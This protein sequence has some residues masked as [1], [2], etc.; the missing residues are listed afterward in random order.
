MML[1]R[2]ADSLYWIG[3]YAERAEHVA[4]LAEVVLA[5]SVEQS[6]GEQTARIAQLSLAANE[7]SAGPEL[8]DTL[9]FGE[10]LG[11]SVV[12]SL[13][14]ARENA[15]Q[16]RD[17]VTTEMWEKLNV[18]HLDLHDG[19]AQG[20]FERGG[21]AWL[22]NL[23]GELHQFRGAADATMSHGE[24]WRFLMLG[25]FVERAQLMTSLLD[26]GFGA[27]AHD[28]PVTEHSAQISLLRMACALEPYLR[29]YTADVRSRYILD[30]LVFDPDFP[31]SLRFTTARIKDNLDELSGDLG[32]GD[33]GEPK[34][35]AGRL[36]SRLAFADPREADGGAVDALL[37]DVAHDCGRIHTAVHRAYVDYPLEANL[38]R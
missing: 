31:R 23:I 4:R 38:P 35:L 15:R 14:F 30:F 3:R 29:V 32:R 18:L 26:A 17:Q 27:A 10:D 22:R 16:V 28:R 8:A 6:G 11:V 34:R 25:A 2:V 36:A 21:V 7:L 12:S 13:A 24:G 1:A 19:Q 20:Q 33:F 37:A 5:T 9:I